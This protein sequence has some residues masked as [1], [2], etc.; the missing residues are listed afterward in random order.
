M[1]GTYEVR[2]I[3]KVESCIRSKVMT[4]IRCVWTISVR[5]HFLCTFFHRCR[6]CPD[7]KPSESKK[8]GR[9]ML[10]GKTVV[11]GVSGSI[12]AYKMANVASMLKKLNCDV[13]V[14]LTEHAAQFITPVT[15]ETLTKNPCVMNE[16][17]RTNP[18][19]IHHIALG[20]SADLLLV[21]PA[22]ANILGKMANGIADDLLTSTIVAATCPVLVSPAMNV[23]M[24]NNPIV[25]DNICRLKNFGYEFIEPA[26]GH[27]ACGVEA[28][29]KLPDESVLV[30][31]IVRKL[32]EADAAMKN[33]WLQ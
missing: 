21:A 27:L 17:E 12:S 29:G 23:H 7:E 32:A 4:F 3:M 13:H 2:F 26:V 14:I 11:L 30:D 28:I 9:I 33:S 8:G 18:P 25:Q 5:A 16:F 19:R 6:M 10:T 24:Y 22:S 20:Q 31:A 1:D 15:F